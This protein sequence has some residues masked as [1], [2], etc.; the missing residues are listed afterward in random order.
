MKKSSWL[1]I[2]LLVGLIF[3]TRFWRL[4]SLPPSPYEEEVALGYEAFSLWKT[5]KDHHGNEWPLLALQSF[6]DWKPALYAYSIIPFLPIFDLSVLAVRLPSALAGICIIISLISLA[7]FLKFNWRWTAL[8]AITSPWLIMFSRAAWEAN[9]ATALIT[10]AVALYFSQTRW[11]KPSRRA[12]AV[13]LA[14]LLLGA[15]AYTYHSA[16]VIVPLLVLGLVAWSHWPLTLSIKT[17]KKKI[18]SM[19]GKLALLLVGFSFVC[20]IPLILFARQPM[21]AQRALETSF[22]GTPELIAQAIAQDIH[23]YVLY[24]RQFT[25]NYLLHLDPRFL[26]VNGDINPRH[27]S[28]QT[29]L[30]Y[31]FDIVVLAVGATLIF[32]KLSKNTVF[33]LLWIAISLVPVAITKDVPHALRILPAAPGFVLLLGL[34]YE[35]SARWIG[36]RFKRSEIGVVVMAGIMG[37]QF[38]SFWYYYVN[39]YPKEWSA[40]WQ[41]GLEEVMTK[42]NEYVLS[43]PDRDVY[44]Y[45]TINRPL[46]YYWFYNKTNPVDVQAIAKD[47]PGEVQRFGKLHIGEPETS[48]A[49]YVH[50]GAAEQ[51][52]GAVLWHTVTYLNGEPAW[53]LYER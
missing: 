22:I 30:F 49:L 45:R 4:D 19:D 43:H 16:R 38:L 31:W 10:A 1:L 46:M 12:L 13:V 8:A 36:S 14:A 9:L 7:R 11:T 28:Q 44:F 15:S 21:I 26:F 18:V 20:L 24:A 2:G 33:L 17:I 40:V 39:A 47:F 51:P 25:K 53:K 42:S 23:P 34:G 48:P 6:G 37:L 41:Y 3:L 5:G 35:R 32:R 52:S 27:T 50:R 29:A